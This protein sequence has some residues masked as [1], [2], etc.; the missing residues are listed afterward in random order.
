[1]AQENEKT[2]HVTKI[3]VQNNMSNA[4]GIA[5]FIFGLIS[6]FF[7]APVFVP[8]A[9]LLGIIAIIKK[10]LAWGIF[11]IICS[12]IGFATSPILLGIFG[13]VSLGTVGLNLEKDMASN[14]N[15]PSQV[16]TPPPPQNYIPQQAY[17][18]CAGYTDNSL[19]SSVTLAC[20]QKIWLDSGC[21]TTGTSYPRNTNSWWSNSPNGTKPVDCDTTHKGT[22]CG[23]GN[24]RTIVNDMRAWATLPDAAHRAGCGR[25]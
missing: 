9:L 5:S 13:L 18:P 2:E 10:Q 23:A 22:Q 1:M 14:Q 11:G 4:L 19:A 15:K 12:I 7:L 3:I 6:I 24:Y 20:L 21:T 16:Y 25:P 8:L 17:N